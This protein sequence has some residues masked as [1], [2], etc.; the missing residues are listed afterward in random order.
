[1]VVRVIRPSNNAAISEI[2]QRAESARAKTG[3]QNQIESEQ[4]TSDES[5]RSGKSSKKDTAFS[6]MRSRYRLLQD[7]KSLG[8]DSWVKQ[9]K[10]QEFDIL[11]QKVMTP[12]GGSGEDAE[13]HLADDIDVGEGKST[14]GWKKVLSETIGNL[15][16]QPDV[17]VT[18]KRNIPQ[19]R[20]RYV[21]THRSLDSVLESRGVHAALHRIKDSLEIS[22]GSVTKPEAESGERSA[23]RDATS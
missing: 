16:R 18:S 21:G 2:R 17:E 12:L 23:G 9:G 14:E 19:R 13:Y 15:Q 22:V 3:A 7:L 10:K 11:T 20:V 1:M 5:A 6:R 8:W 4:N